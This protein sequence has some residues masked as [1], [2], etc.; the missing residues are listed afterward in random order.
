MDEHVWN[1]VTRCH[2]V[3]RQEA[4]L[5]GY[6]RFRVKGEVYPGIIEDGQSSVH[7]QLVTINSEA[8]DGLLKQLDIYEGINEGLYKRMTVHVKVLN[9]QVECQTYVFQQDW[10]VTDQDWS[11][12]W[13]HQ[14][15][16]QFEQLL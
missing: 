10:L 8:D 12:D 4:I 14:H 2:L 1:R 6:R 16:K 3:Q 7:G 11:L 13:F 5:N 9:E 15:L